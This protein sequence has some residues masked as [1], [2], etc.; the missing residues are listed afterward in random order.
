MKKQ[1][2]ITLIALIITIIVMLIL[3]SVSVSVALNGGLF[4]AAKQAADKTELALKDELNLSS[5]ETFWRQ[6]GTTLKE[7]TKGEQIDI[8]ATVIG[9][10]LPDISDYDGITWQVL[11]VENGKLL[12]TTS[13]TIGEKTLVGSE[14]KWDG[15]NKKWTALEKEL[16]D[17]CADKISLE[18]TKAEKIR[19]I[20]VED[21]NRVTG[22]NPLED[23]VY[24]NTYGNPVGVDFPSG[25]VYWTEDTAYT[26]VASDYFTNTDSPAYTMLFKDS[27]FKDSEDRNIS[28]F[29]AS[30][31]VYRNSGQNI[32]S[33]LR[34]VGFSNSNICIGNKEFYTTEYFDE[35]DA[36]SQQRGTIRPVVIMSSDFV[37]V[38]AE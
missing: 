23:D 31:Y 29:L 6:N 22:Y 33:G 32:Y 25:K 14:E 16:D 24:K 3:V 36:F 9:E 8:G 7:L 20:T 5:M 11:G 12:L 28:Y 17:F 38:I 34:E 2:G 10:G 15:A 35:E 26:Y 1:N 19:S 37:P 13:T 4:D 18:E 30:S 27:L 21:I